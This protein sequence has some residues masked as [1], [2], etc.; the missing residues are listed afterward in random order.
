MISDTKQQEMKY[1]F[2]TEGK[3]NEKELPVSHFLADS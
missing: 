2:I 3:E 1:L